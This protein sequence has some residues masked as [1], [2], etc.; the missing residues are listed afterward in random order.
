MDEIASVFL[1]LS[2]E[3]AVVPT[4]EVTTLAMVEMVFV[5]GKVGSVGA[6]TDVGVILEDMFVISELVKAEEITELFLEVGPAYV[7]GVTANVDVCMFM[8]VLGVVEDNKVENDPTSLEVSEETTV[9]EKAESLTGIEDISDK[10]PEVATEGLFKQP[11]RV[12]LE[13]LVISIVGVVETFLEAKAVTLT[14][15]GDIL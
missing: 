7:T 2:R 5:D 14:G 3:E 4:S 9:G 10:G 15:D 6:K 8:V 12:V 11:G 1:E 13:G